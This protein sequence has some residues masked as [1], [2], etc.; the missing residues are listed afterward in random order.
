MRRS[1]DA[2]MRNLENWKLWKEKCNE[3]ILG[4]NGLILWKAIRKTWE[5]EKKKYGIK[6]SGMIW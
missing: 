5:L 6:T 2:S 3:V 4:G 1:A